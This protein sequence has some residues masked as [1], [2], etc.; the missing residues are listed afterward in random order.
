MLRRLSQRTLSINE[1]DDEEGQRMVTDWESEFD[2]DDD[3]ADERMSF[4]EKFGGSSDASEAVVNGKATARGN[5]GRRS[6][7]G[8]TPPG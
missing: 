1:K 6:R 5:R 2:D 8:S 7:C 3:E 4:L